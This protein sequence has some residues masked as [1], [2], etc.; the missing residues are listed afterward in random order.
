LKKHVFKF[1]DFTML[2]TCITAKFS[3]V[4]CSGWSQGYTSLQLH[5]HMIL[6]RPQVLQYRYIYIIFGTPL[7]RMEHTDE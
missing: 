3:S 6:A 1:S 2:C 7:A 4:H 5:S